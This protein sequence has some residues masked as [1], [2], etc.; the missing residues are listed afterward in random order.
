MESG[1]SLLMAYGNTVRRQKFEMF[2]HYQSSGPNPLTH[3]P[4]LASWHLNPLLDLQALR[5]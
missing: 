1:A 3:A 5:C 2:L 4:L